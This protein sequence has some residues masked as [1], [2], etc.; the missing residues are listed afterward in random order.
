[1]S[2]TSNTFLD[3]AIGSLQDNLPI[4]THDAASE[5]NRQEYS[6]Q[7][8][9]I[10]LLGKN[11]SSELKEEIA[12]I[13]DEIANIISARDSGYEE[14]LVKRTSREIATLSLHLLQTESELAEIKA[15]EVDYINQI[16][17][18]EAEIDNL[19]NAV[20]SLFSSTSWKLTA[21]LRKVVKL[22]KRN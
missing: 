5:P 22:L 19:R 12:R 11:L 1:M 21:P 8:G 18:L 10:E 13:K 7:P 16:N 4:T 2:N 9:A 20:N 6:I 17:V 15:K 3:P 14:N